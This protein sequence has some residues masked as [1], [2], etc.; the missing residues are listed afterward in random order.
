MRLLGGA[1]GAVGERRG[2]AILRLGCSLTC[3]GGVDH[4]TSRRANPSTI[5]GSEGDGVGTELL[6]SSDGVLGSSAIG[7]I[8]TTATATSTWSL[9]GVGEGVGSTYLSRSL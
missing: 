9:V 6:Q 2:S 5:G 3:R 1:E 4:H 7:H 8:P